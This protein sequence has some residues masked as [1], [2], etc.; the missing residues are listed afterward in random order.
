[1]AQKSQNQ[2][3]CDFDELFDDSHTFHDVGL[4]ADFS[5]NPKH[6]FINELNDRKH[7]KCFENVAQLSKG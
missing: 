1:V 7:R 4:A 3:T 6:F 5:C 2:L